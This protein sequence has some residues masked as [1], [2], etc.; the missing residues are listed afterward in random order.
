MEEIRFGI[1][2]VRQTVRG[3]RI[4]RQSCTDASSRIGHARKGKGK[5]AANE[6]DEARF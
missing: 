2:I 1:K 5:S 6:R 3:K 4:S